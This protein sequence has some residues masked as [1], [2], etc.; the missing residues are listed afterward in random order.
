M[1]DWLVGWVATNA[2]GLLFKTIFNEEFA[3]DLAKDYAKDFFKDRFN[4]VGT[5]LFHK[6]PLQKAIVKALKEFLQLVQEE[7]K[8]RK[9]ADEEIKKLSK[10]LKIFIYNKSVKEILGK[11]FDADCDSLDD[12]TLQSTWQSLA[13]PPLP[14]LYAATG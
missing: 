14:R 12:Q 8:F 9:V 1:V 6:E 2:A 4:N 11:A 13:L 5:A 3:K 7:L 10:P